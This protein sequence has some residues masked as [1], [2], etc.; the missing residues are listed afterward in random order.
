MLTQWLLGLRDLWDW[1]VSDRHV[2]MI[3]EADEG[4]IQGGNDDVMAVG[5]ERHCG[6]R[7]CSQGSAPTLCTYTAQAQTPDQCA[8]ISW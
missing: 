8:L 4:P 6:R 2:V 1:G 3:F 5:I 7:G